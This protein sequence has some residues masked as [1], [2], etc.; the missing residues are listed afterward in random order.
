MASFS[1][2]RHFSWAGRHLGSVFR[3]LRAVGT[4]VFSQTYRHAPGISVTFY[5]RFLLNIDIPNPSTPSSPVS[6]TLYL[7]LE[8]GP[9]LPD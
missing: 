1:R 3:T 7:L 2:Q 5:L 6:R 4:L 8:I 9:K